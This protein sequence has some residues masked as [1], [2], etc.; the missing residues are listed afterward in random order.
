M[1]ILQQLYEGGLITYM[2][3]D[4]T[5][6]SEEVLD[7]T[8]KIIK[9]KYGEKYNNRKQYTKKS[10]NSQEAHEAIRPTDFCF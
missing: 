4:S 9:E 1:M 3:T 10:K 7:A 5:L 2:R 8:E 6:L